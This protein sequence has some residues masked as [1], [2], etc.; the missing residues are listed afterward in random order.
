MINFLIMLLSGIGAIAILL[1]SIGMLRMPDLYLRLSV[2]TKAATLGVGLILIGAALYFQN[3]GVTSRVLAIIFF[4]TVTAPVSAQLIARASYLIKTKMWKHTIIDELEGMY[5]TNTDKLHGIS[6]P[7][8][9]DP[10]VLK[11]EG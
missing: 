11:K 8:D 2:T 6:K 4:I 9:N 5:E 3:V 7:D 1:A 10:Q